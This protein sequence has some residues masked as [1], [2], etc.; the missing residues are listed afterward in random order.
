MKKKIKIQ[1]G[2]LNTDLFALLN[3]LPEHILFH[4][5]HN[6]RHP[7]GIYNVTFRQVM[8]SIKDVIIAVESLNDYDNL[9][10]GKNE[11]L[12]I[13]E[14]SL[15][16]EGDPIQR[17][18]LEAL[19]LEIKKELSDISSA[20]NAEVKTYTESIKGLID[21][22]M[23]FIDG[24]Y[25]IIKSFYPASSVN[26]VIPF[27][28]R[29]LETIEKKLINEF[30][31]QIK[32]YREHVAPIA[33][34][35]KHN[36]AKINLLRFKT[37]F[38]MINGYFIEGVDSQGNL[39]S[40]RQIHKQFNNQDTAFSI[41][42]DLKFHLTNFYFICHHLKVVIEKIIKTK[43]N[44]QVDISGFVINDSKDYLEITKLVEGL[45]NLY[46]PDEAYKP[47]PVL[48]T[49]ENYIEVSLPSNGANLILYGGVEIK[50]SLSGDGV[51]KSYRLQYWEPQAHK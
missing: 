46:F 26:K 10:S 14:S 20:G 40:D 28:D 5:E 34:K 23:S 38:G 41:N 6:S 51:T 7:L 29:W 13:A 35:I 22:I 49:N 3:A 1:S 24:A 4:H 31:E 32:E 45:P 50:S 17:N 36:Y 48:V 47:V 12:K 16:V 43:Y 39:G 44:I 11:Q 8:T 18:A 9:I 19:I 21:S 42:R 37:E 25:H 33:N 27:A 30:K 2:N 15:I